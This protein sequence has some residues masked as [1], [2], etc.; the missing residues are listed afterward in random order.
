MTDP[1]MAKRLQKQAQPGLSRSR[2]RVGLIEHRQN[3]FVLNMD[4]HP[5]ALNLVRISAFNPVK[6][7]SPTKLCLVCLGWAVQVIIHAPS[8]VIRQSHVQHFFGKGS[9]HVA[10]RLLRDEAFMVSF[11][12]L[13]S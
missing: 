12:G 8:K 3:A 4:V 7:D 11:E 9:Q 13:T 10:S 6:Q 5:C 1:D 2:G